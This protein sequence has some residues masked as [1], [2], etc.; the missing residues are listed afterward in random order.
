MT[1]ESVQEVPE[2]FMMLETAHVVYFRVWFITAE[3]K[4]IQQTL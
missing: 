4:K 3:G 1:C 2:I